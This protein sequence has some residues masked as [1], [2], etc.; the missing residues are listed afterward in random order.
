MKGDSAIY[1]VLEE[2][3][4]PLRGVIRGLGLSELEHKAYEEMITNLPYAIVNRI[5]AVGGIVRSKEQAD[6]PVV[7]E[8]TGSLDEP[9]FRREHRTEIRIGDLIFSGI[10]VTTSFDR[11]GYLEYLARAIARGCVEGVAMRLDEQVLVALRES[12]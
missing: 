12:L 2:A 11:E 3:L 5:R 10:Q 4:A 6:W 9:P 8:T 7:V 1:E